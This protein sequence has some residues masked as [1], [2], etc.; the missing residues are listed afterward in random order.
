MLPIDSLTFYFLILLLGCVAGFLAGLLG[1]GGGLV[2][3][4]ALA[5]ILPAVGHEPAYVMHVA[6][7]TSLASIVFTSIASVSAHHRHGAVLWSVMRR[8]SGGILLGAFAGAMLVDQLDT[9]VL[10]IIF[11]VFVLLVSLQ[12]A[13]S[14]RANAHA[15][16]PN[17]ENLSLA[18]AIIGVVSSLVGIGGG[19]MSVPYLMWHGVAIRNAVAT[20]AANGLP[21][22]IA[23]ASGYMITGYVAVGWQGWQLGYVNLLILIVLVCG[24]VVFAPFGAKMAHR[25]NT[26]WLKQIFALLLAAIGVRMLLW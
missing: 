12:M 8:M 23:G 19:T 17:I 22:A 26:Q 13:A 16:L 15:Q 24:S 2:I 11:G 4:P 20:A 10:Q 6:L 18:G 5:L 25:M 9:A 1:I 7:G 14:W 21:I 3:V